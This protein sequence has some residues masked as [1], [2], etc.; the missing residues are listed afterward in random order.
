M[1]SGRCF[2][3]RVWISNN[4]GILIWIG[5]FII[6]GITL[7]T[8][9][10]GAGLLVPEGEQQIERQ[11]DENDDYD[12][13]VK[14]APVK[15]KEND[16]EPE[17]E[18]VIET[19]TVGKPYS[20][21]IAKEGSKNILILGKDK[22]DNLYDT[23]GIVS[24]DK[25]NKV[26]KLVMIPRDTYIEYNEDVLSKMGELGI[27]H[28]PGIHKINS[29]HKIGTMIGHKGKFESG[30]ISFLA[31]VIEE[32]FSLELHDYIMINVRGFR[33]LVDHLG[34]V[35]INVP[36]RMDYVDPTQELV[37]DLQKGMQR[38]DGFN[39]EGFVRFRQGKREDGTYFEIGDI[40][41][42]KNQLN[43]MKQLIKQKG[44]IKNIGK[45]PGIIEILGKNVEHS[46]GFGDVLSSYMGLAANVIT[47]EYEVS[48]IN[49]DSEKTTRIDGAA[50]LVLE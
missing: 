48:S 21:E 39:A 27:L 5:V 40:G 46:I 4:K 23:I 12:V 47:D 37:I 22:V 26:L 29:T 50:Y 38:L 13:M 34:G 49:I 42:K 31:E 25:N 2:K 14:P 30:S 32:K 28:S 45:I 43:F 9:A 41:R 6:L 24:I 8:V 19:L 18:Q 20:Q 33:E 17:P 35:E 36:Y 44:T 16:S 11:Y 7:L 10:S 3:V 15:V 1:D